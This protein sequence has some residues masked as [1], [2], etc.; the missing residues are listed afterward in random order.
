MKCRMGHWFHDW[1][2]AGEVTITSPKRGPFDPRSD[3][4]RTETRQGYVCSQCGAKKLKE[5]EYDY[6]SY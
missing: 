6:P 4:E 3:E 5:I 2:F 1:I